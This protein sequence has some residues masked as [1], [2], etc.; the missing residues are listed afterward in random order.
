MKDGVAYLVSN[1]NVS[2]I[3]PTGH[4]TIMD[5]LLWGRKVRRPKPCHLFLLCGKIIEVEEGGLIPMP[6]RFAEAQRRFRFSY[7]LPVVTYFPSWVF[8]ICGGPWKKS[9]W[10]GGWISW[11]FDHRSIMEIRL[12][13]RATAEKWLRRAKEHWYI[14]LVAK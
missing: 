12:K 8:A 2:T 6:E 3:E 11:P 1:E 9:Q 5:I 7:C 14:P 4:A 13:N 10:W